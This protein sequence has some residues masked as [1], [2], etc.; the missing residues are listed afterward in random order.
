[1]RPE[2]EMLAMTTP[3]LPA[4]IAAAREAE[5]VAPGEWRIDGTHG[6]GNVFVGT[7]RET[8]IIEVRGYVGPP[9][10]GRPALADHVVAA[11]PAAVLALADLAVRAMRMADRLGARVEW[12]EDPQWSDDC[13]EQDADWRETLA[14]FRAELEAID[15]DGAA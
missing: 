13:P 15:K 9:G 10:C 5:A 3:N 4:L 6:K 1:M 14:Q 7:A 12:S 8:G 11:N 2:R